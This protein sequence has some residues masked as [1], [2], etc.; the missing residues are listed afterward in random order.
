M[1]SRS[2]KKTC[3]SSEIIGD[4]K[5][6]F[7]LPREVTCQCDVKKLGGLIIKGKPCNNW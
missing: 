7:E 1:Y 3:E 4:L 5:E 6:V 2:P